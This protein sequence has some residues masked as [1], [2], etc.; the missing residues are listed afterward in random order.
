M[1]S[2]DY[3]LV[4][5]DFW[6]VIYIQREL[7]QSGDIQVPAND[8]VAYEHGFANHSCSPYCRDNSKLYN[9]VLDSAIKSSMNQRNFTSYMTTVMDQFAPISVKNNLKHPYIITV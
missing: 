3:V 8:V 7:A 9:S 2:F 5:V 4:E 1:I 6:D